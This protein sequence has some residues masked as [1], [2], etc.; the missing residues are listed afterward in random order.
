[1]DKSSPLVTCILPTFYNRRLVEQS[2]A[3][4][5]L[6][7]YPNR[8]LIF[9]DDGDDPV[10]DLAADPRIRYVRLHYHATRGGKRNIACGI[11]AGEVIV[12]WDENDWMANWRISY[13]LTQ[14]LQ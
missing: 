11:A 4:F 13:Q 1:M 7:D 6:Q 3:Y 9:V 5:R 2:I 10:N 8:E 14:L 12:H